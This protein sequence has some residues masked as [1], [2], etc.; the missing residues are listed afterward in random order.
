M[1]KTSAVEVNIQAVLAL[2]I[3]PS[4]ARAIS[5]LESKRSPQALQNKY[6]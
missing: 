5:V 3:S 2:E 1:N 6:I 4:D